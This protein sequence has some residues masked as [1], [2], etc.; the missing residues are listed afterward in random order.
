[1]KIQKKSR[2]ILMFA[3]QIAVAACITACT[4]KKSAQ[5]TNGGTPAKEQEGD[6]SIIHP[7]INPNAKEGMN[8]YKYPNGIVKAREYY[9]MGK[10]NGECQ[11]FYP[12]GLLWSDEYF[13]N[14]YPDGTITVY[15]D[16]F[17][18][19]MYQ[20]QYRMG[21]PTGIWKY[22]NMNGSPKRTANYDKKA[23]NSAL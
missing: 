23:P 3:C 6:S 12:D 1:M 16:S 17:G 10:K 20:G 4:G 9:S 19:I 2:M 5:V 18:K 21:K 7:V 13:T 8:T 14:G 11:A 15:Y 22:L